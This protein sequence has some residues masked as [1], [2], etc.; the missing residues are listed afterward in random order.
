MP[1][2]TRGAIDRVQAFIDGR[3]A[4]RSRLNLRGNPVP[5]RI[6]AEYGYLDIHDLQAVVD[7]ATSGRSVPPT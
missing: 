5:D 2:A 3:K 6:I 7:A 4:F 1:D